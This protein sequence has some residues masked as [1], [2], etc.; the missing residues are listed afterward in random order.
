[1]VQGRETLI[2]ISKHLENIEDPK[3][4]KTYGFRIE[5]IVSSMRD[6]KLQL[7][8]DVDEAI[9]RYGSKFDYTAENY[10]WFWFESPEWTWKNLCGRAGW[11]VLSKSDLELQDFFLELMN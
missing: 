10:I 1:M 5:D 8:H 3:I 6:S 4:L 9:E 2:D 11:M 7:K